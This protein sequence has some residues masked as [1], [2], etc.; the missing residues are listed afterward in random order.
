MLLTGL[1]SPVR[2]AQQNGYSMEPSY[3]GYNPPAGVDEEE[4]DAI[5]CVQRVVPV[6]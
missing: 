1:N 5:R 6:P 3:S 2:H 4:S